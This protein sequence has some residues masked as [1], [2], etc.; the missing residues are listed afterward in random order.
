MTNHTE[1]K[2]AGVITRNDW[3]LPELRRRYAGYFRRYIQD[4]IAAE[5][6]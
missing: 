1:G 3:R 5:G 4:R 2:T 6:A